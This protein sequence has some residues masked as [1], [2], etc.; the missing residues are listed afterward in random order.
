MNETMP[1]SI[2]VLDEAKRVFE[3]NDSFGSYYELRA[4]SIAGGTWKAP[5]IIPELLK[6]LRSWDY[7][8][9][10]VGVEGK[11]AVYAPPPF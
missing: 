7:F 9:N 2:L 1:N 4:L 8:L 6:R 5:P 10:R 11:T 3:E